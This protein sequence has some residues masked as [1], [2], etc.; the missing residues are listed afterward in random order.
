MRADRLRIL[1]RTFTLATLV[2]AAAGCEPEVGRECGQESFVLD[3]VL[4][5]NDRNDLVQDL[6]FESCSQG[7][8][9][10]VNGTRPFCTRR[11]ETNLDCAA[12]GFECRELINF[13]RLACQDWTAERD[14]TQEDGS[15]SEAPILYCAPIQLDAKCVVGKRDCDF[16]RGD[17][18]TCQTLEDS[19][20]PDGAIC[21][22]SEVQAGEGEGEG[23]SP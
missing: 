13:G 15:P 16:G 2:A 14:C 7:L 6:G 22:L 20:W 21:P 18:T 19:A 1:V 12:E 8:C 17:A 23:E 9:A 3:R 11:C 10:S 5:E 4:V